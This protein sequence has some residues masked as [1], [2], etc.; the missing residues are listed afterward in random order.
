MIQSFYDGV[1][2]PGA[3]TEERKKDFDDLCEEYGITQDFLIKSKK[4]GSK[5]AY[6]Y[7]DKPYG[8]TYRVNKNFN[9]SGLCD[10]VNSR[11]Y[12][13]FKLMSM[14]SHGTSLYL[15]M[16]GMASVDHILSIISLF[17][18]NA[19]KLVA[20]YCPDGVSPRFYRLIDVL[21]ECFEECIQAFKSNI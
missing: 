5:E 19:Y 1:K 14:Y 9:F 4:N 8:W 2:I 18:Y 16:G 20:G 3:K 15:K 10:I 17:Y 13:D 21:E 11:D 12:S 7:I 6:A